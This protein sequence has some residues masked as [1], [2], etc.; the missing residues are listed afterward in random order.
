MASNKPSIFLYSLVIATVAE[1]LGLFYWVKFVDNGFIMLGIAVITI[2]LLAER[3]SVYLLI[4]AVWGSEPPHRKLI[5]N[6][7][8]AGMGETIAW[9]V[10]LFLADGPLGLFLASV[11]LG[12]VLLFE[13]SIQIGFFMQSA[14]FKHVTDPMTI[15]FSALEGVVAF[16]WLYFVR[17]DHA[18]WGAVV[19]FVGLTVEHII[20]GSVIGTDKP[21]VSSSFA[22]RQ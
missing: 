21:T 17:A 10:W 4:H 22:Q 12:V 11:L 9:L 5:L 16:F 8:L 15:V 2:G 18:F 14:Y 7:F 6:L 3:I 19:L 20:Q 1:F 13:H